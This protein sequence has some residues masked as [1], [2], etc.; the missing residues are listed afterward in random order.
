MYNEYICDDRP[1]EVP[2]K[3]AKMTNKE[4]E[5]EFEKR[6]VEYKERTGYNENK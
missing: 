5:Q 1:V 4:I 3:I 2:E 6:F